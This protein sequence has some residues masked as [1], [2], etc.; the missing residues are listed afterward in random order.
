MLNESNSEK[1]LLKLF[2]LSKGRKKSRPVSGAASR[3]SVLIER[4][5]SVPEYFGES[6][7]VTTA[8]SSHI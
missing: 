5:V 8:S 4:L 3:K 2:V 6:V 1:L 7:V